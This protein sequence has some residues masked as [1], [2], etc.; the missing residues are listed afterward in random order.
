MERSWYFEGGAI[1][2]LIEIVESPSEP[3][4]G[5]GGTFKFPRHIRL[6]LLSD[7]KEDYYN[8]ITTKILDDTAIQFYGI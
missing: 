7:G 2:R 8:T 1:W 5:A 3:Q 6:V 4:L